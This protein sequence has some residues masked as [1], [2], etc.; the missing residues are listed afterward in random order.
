MKLILL[1]MLSSFILSNT[2]SQNVGIG[3]TTPQSKLEVKNPGSSSIRISSNGFNDTTQLIFSNRTPTDAGTDMRINLNREEGLAFSSRSDLVGN[4]SDSILVISPLGYVGIN[5]NQPFEKLDIRGNINITGSLK[6]NGNPGSPGQVLTSNGSFS[7]IWQNVIV[8]KIGFSATGTAPAVSNHQSISSSVD[9]KVMIFNDEDRDDGS[10][11]NP[12]TG[13]ATVTFEGTYHIDI[14]VS[15][16]NSESGNYQLTFRKFSSSGTDLGIQRLTHQTIASGLS[17]QNIQLNISTDIYLL[18]GQ[19]IEVY[20]LQN[21][22]FAQEIT[23]SF[24]S[25]FNMH[26]VN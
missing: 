26:K 14:S 1:L 13:R 7:P 12:V 18:A 22:G 15:Y 20:T 8:P 9:T 11:Y 24:Y 25:W 3:T 21:S 16:E 23:G 6:S 4:N 2:Y 5:N 17:N 10:I 19:S